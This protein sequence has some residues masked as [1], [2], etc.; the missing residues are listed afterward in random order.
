MPSTHRRNVFP[1]PTIIGAFSSNISAI[2]PRYTN[3]AREATTARIGKRYSADGTH[4][5][6]FAPLP[7]RPLR[8]QSP[9]YL[10]PAS[11]GGLVAYN[12]CPR[13]SRSKNRRRR[14][15]ECWN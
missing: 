2:H 7:R 10:R 15:I 14:G 5:S 1:A 3:F 11:F 8:P 9:R 13:R 4:P 6:T 12:L